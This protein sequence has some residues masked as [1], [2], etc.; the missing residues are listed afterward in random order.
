MQRKASRSLL[1]HEHFHGIKLRIVTTSNVSLQFYL[2]YIIDLRRSFELG[3]K[4]NRKHFSPKFRC[5]NAMQFTQDAAQFSRANRYSCSFSHHISIFHCIFS[6]AQ[7]NLLPMTVCQI[8]T[9][10]RKKKSPDQYYI[11]LIPEPDMI[12]VGN[13]SQGVELA[14]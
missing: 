8:K 14:S 12:I 10:H 2:S 5:G 13:T 1:H 11:R 9:E 3:L 4:Q 7:L 6:K